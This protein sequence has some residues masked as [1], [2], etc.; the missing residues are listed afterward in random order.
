MWTSIEG[1]CDFA[2]MRR[3][4]WVLTDQIF[5][6]NEKAVIYLWK[7]DVVLLFLSKRKVDGI[8]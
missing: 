8:K 6:N 5:K 4:V 3:C 2:H 7:V 1:P